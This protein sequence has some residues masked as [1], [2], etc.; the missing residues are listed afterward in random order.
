MEHSGSG[1]LPHGSLDLARLQVAP[2]LTVRDRAERFSTF[3]EGEFERDL[4][5]GR[6]ILGPMDRE[7]LVRDPRTGES[8]PMLMFGSNNYLGLANHPYVRE[9]TRQGVDRWG[10]GL[11]GPPLLNGTMS[12]HRR[13]E[14]RVSSLKGKGSALLYSSGYSANVGW[15]SALAHRKDIVVLDE[16]C[17]ASLYDGARASKAT[18]LPFRHSSLDDLEE[19]LAMARRRHPVNL[20]VVVEGIYS[21]DGDLAPLD[22]IV[23]LSKKHD[24]F[25]ALDD[26]H[27]TGV[28]GATGAGAAEHF[29]VEEEVDLV[30]GTFSKALAASGAFVA[31]DPEVVRYLRFFSRSHFFSASM[32]PVTLSA[33]HAGLDVLEREPERRRRLFDNVRYLTESLTSV[34]IPVWSPSAI[35]P[36]RVPSRVRA[37]CRRVHEA[38]VFVNAIEYP[39]V[40]RGKE[41]FRVSV[42][43]EHTHPDIDR[44]VEALDRAFAAEGVPRGG[45]S[46]SE[47]K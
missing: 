4:I 20:F 25:V 16:F 24:A 34:G 47:L 31:S 36:V 15:L 44:L 32:P 5:V 43:S 29:G 40:P 30:M 2:D 17:H 7:V 42:M 37:V 22:A 38:G 18:I 21:M 26:A 27:A 9:Q 33:I 39:A 23:A 3:L 35:V 8:V 41:R 1:T 14:E 12:L 6:E 28:L 13:L 10:V 46:A 19:T 45:E 11:G